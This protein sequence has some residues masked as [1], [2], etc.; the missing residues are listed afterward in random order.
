[1]EDELMEPTE[2]DTSEASEEVLEEPVEG[3]YTIKV[4]GEQHQVSLE[5]L[6]DGYQRQADYTRK[7]QELADERRRLQ[8]AEAI[9]SSLENNPAET[10][11][12]LG[13]AFG[14]VAQPPAPM[15]H[16]D[17]DW[18]DDEEP[19]QVDAT[20]MRVSE[21]EYRLAQQDRL[22]RRNN[23]EKQ[24]NSLK[25]QYGDFN[26]TELFQH[27]LRHK[28]GNLEAALTHMRFGEVSDKAT[29]LEK[30]QE[31]TGAKR[32][33]AVVESGG[34]TAANAVKT[35]AKNPPQTIREAFAQAKKNLT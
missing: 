24:V 5:E 34:S 32:D 7:T 19:Q 1:M 33:A 35:Q 15:R 27:A 25:D 31:R 26:S 16:S 11:N 28:I 20:A 8:Q 3:A 4:D 13:E 9:V 12:A 29:K 30:D 17:D 22:A 14:L 18:Y 10:L 6:Q 2:V 21:L 23:I